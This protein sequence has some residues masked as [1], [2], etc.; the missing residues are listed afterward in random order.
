[1]ALTPQDSQVFAREVDEELRREQ[2]STFWQ[3]YGRL[4]LIGI[5]VALLA[6]AGL[7]Y[8]QH[9]QRTVRERTGEKFDQALEALAQND[10]GKAAAP[11]AEVVSSSSD[12]YR[13][14]GKIT[15]ADLLLQKNDL[16][17]A[18]AKF[19]EV[20]NDTS[21]DE[22]FRQLALI[23]QTS[24]EFDTLPPQQVIDRLK[25]LTV[26]DS[27]WL[28][29]AGELVA[30]AYLKLKRKKDA[31]QLFGTIAQGKDVPPSIRQRAVQMASA[32]GVEIQVPT[33]S[34]EESKR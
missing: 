6:L 16:K 8:W 17:S 25:P 4:L 5:V 23:R 19:A 32:M 34:Q 33:A 18:A 2:L 10:A 30:A 3:R 28:G 22:P 21:L 29:S 31:G 20:A 11:L 1:M 24:A 26:A 12:G 7:L 27:P 15:Q 14:M 9:H 13:A